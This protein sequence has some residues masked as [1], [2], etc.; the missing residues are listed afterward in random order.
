MTI[1]TALRG[2]LSKSLKSF[3]G[4][5]EGT[6]KS[7]HTRSSYRLDLLDFFR[8]LEKKGYSL[9]KLKLKQIGSREIEAYHG[10]LKRDA[11][12]ANTRRRKLMTLRKWL[13]FLKVRKKVDTDLGKLIPTPEKSERV[14]P[15]TDRSLVLERI[16]ALGESTDLELRNKVVL[17]LL[18]ETGASVS[19]IAKLRSDQITLTRKRIRVEFLGKK[20]RICELSEAGEEMI[21]GLEKL[22]FDAGEKAALF[23][24]F[25]RHGK[26]RAASVTPRGVELLVSALGKSWDLDLT[27]R[28]LRH[29]VV[30]AW[31]KEG[32]SRVEIQKR[33]GLT[34]SYSMR[35]YEPYFKTISGAKPDTKGGQEG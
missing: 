17:F 24:G 32:V 35:M 23:C 6:Q 12:K 16:L 10:H 14:P 22:K 1:E 9:S 20:P 11:Q 29:S 31:F 34:T 5:L 25:N 13:Q 7:A 19:E 33:L 26:L 18:L 30:V 21:R 8:F 3:L 15:V 27:P 4:Y 28:R 2:E